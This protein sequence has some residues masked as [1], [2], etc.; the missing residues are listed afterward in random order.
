MDARSSGNNR[1]NSAN[2]KIAVK[3]P[4][5]SFACAVFETA[6]SYS[7]ITGKCDVGKATEL[8]RQL[9]N[10]RFTLNFWSKLLLLYAF[11]LYNYKI[12]K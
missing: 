5:I 10:P 7:D 6:Y 12:I 3:I 11:M 4:H 2:I 1:E 8:H 9:A